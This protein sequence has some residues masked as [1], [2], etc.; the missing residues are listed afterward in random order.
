MNSDS[1]EFINYFKN[2]IRKKGFIKDITLNDFKDGDILLERFE[3]GWAGDLDIVYYL[4]KK[5]EKSI[6]VTPYRSNSP[7]F[8]DRDVEFKLWGEKIRYDEKKIKDDG[9]GMRTIQTCS[10]GRC[11]IEGRKF[12]QISNIYDHPEDKD[13]FNIKSNIYDILINKES[14]IKCCFI[15]FIDD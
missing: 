9:F 8:Y 4:I 3:I 1:I 10:G 13:L 7:K 11:K 14:L 15:H 6:I 2:K 12:K 5:N